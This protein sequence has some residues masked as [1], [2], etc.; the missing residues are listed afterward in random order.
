MTPGTLSAPFYLILFLLNPSIPQPKVIFL[1]QS[2]LFRCSQ[3]R[4]TG[5]WWGWG[6]W[7]GGGWWGGGG[8]GGRIGA[9]LEPD[10]ALHSFHLGLVLLL[11]V[12]K[13]RALPYA[14]C[15]ARHGR[16]PPSELFTPHGGV[17]TRPDQPQRKNST[18]QGQRRG[19]KTFSQ[20]SGLFQGAAGFD[21]RFN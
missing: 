17:F 7:C 18:L 15:K 20:L 14:V 8:G 3:N 10:T 12:N 6:G 11:S 16:P 5:G 1:W 2:V 4:L 19:V 13:W 9:S 21:T